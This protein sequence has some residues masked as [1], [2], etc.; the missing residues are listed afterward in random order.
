MALQLLDGNARPCHVRRCQHVLVHRPRGHPSHVPGYRT[1]SVSPEVPASLDH[2]SASQETVRGRVSSS[3]YKSDGTL[4]LTVSLPANSRAV[5]T[6]PRQDEGERIQHPR[7]ARPS[8][9]GARSV[10][11]RVGSGTWTF[12]VG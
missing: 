4:R 12:V 5:V 2:L 1:M 7:G 9:S 10:S 3:W 11:Y 6:V 8:Q